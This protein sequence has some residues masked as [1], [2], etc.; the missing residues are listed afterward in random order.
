MPATLLSLALLLADAPVDW[1]AAVRCRIV[2][3]TNVSAHSSELR[4][5]YGGRS[6]A[7]VKGIEMFYLARPDLQ[8]LAGRWPLAA[9]VWFRCV[10]QQLR[11]VGLSRVGAPWDEDAGHGDATVPGVCWGQTWTQA[12]GSQPWTSTGDDLSAVVLGADGGTFEI[13][14]VQTARDGWLW[15]ELPATILAAQLNGRGHGFCVSDESGQTRFNNDLITREERASAPYLEVLTVEVDPPP[16]APQPASAAP[17]VKSTLPPLPTLPPEP[18]PAPVTALWAAPGSDS[19]HPVQGGLLNQQGAAYGQPVDRSAGRQNAVWT[20]DG[21]VLSGARGET[22]SAQLVIESPTAPTSEP[23]LGAWSGGSPGPQTVSGVWYLPLPQPV[24]EVAVP[25]TVPWQPLPGRR[26]WTRLVELDISPTAAPGSYT[27]RWRWG[28]QEL[29]MRLTVWRHSL[30]ARL[31]FQVSLNTY[32]R[33]HGQFGITDEASD[34]ALGI[35]REYHRTAHRHRA[36][37]APLTYGQSGRV[38][39]GAGPRLVGDG[40]QPA[41]DFRDFDRRF[42]ALLDGTA[43]ADLPRAGVPVDHLYL[44]FH[45][46]WPCP[47][48]EYAFRPAA[49]G[50]PE[51]ITEHALRGPL[52]PADGFSAAWQQR[53]RHVAQ[54]F[55][56]HLQQP[57]WRG[58]R[59]QA[60]FNNKYYFRDPAQGGRGTSWWLLDEPMHRTDWDA[61][62]FLSGLLGGPGARREG[63]G[64]QWRADISR[65]QWMPAAVSERLDLLVISSTWFPYRRRLEALGWGARGKEA[66]LYGAALPP[67]QPSLQTAAWCLRAWCGGLDGVVPWDSVG[68]DQNYERASELALL[69]PGRR[70]G[71]P[72]ALPSLR[73]KAL[74]DG[75]QECERLNLLLARLPQHSRDEIAAALAGVLSLDA[76][77]R[78]RYTDDAGQ[79]VFTGLTPAGWERWRQTVA[80]W[81]ESAT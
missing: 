15:V 30:P 2:A 34:A 43:F 4:F 26:Y 69:L 63:G 70:Y 77:A 59:F 39:W 14:E 40:P 44:P 7:R 49:T 29:P 62:E 73:L 24:A 20:R 42:G 66:W 54:Q 1:S 37:F 23:E 53:Y 33:Q 64:L 60:Y 18:Q 10:Q 5:T 52:R 45:E 78:S 55:A 48:A 8:P 79:M 35:E 65:P 36:T 9:R 11:R 19:V 28:A 17:A 75:Q 27:A 38:E 21:L 25:L 6:R 76:E 47:V 31:T 67:G 61:L 16:A 57:A 74:R 80:A 71:Q 50:Y 13:H 81:L 22:V 56:V 58:T 12:G 51:M 46:N 72:I 68:G 3:D 32:G 41:C